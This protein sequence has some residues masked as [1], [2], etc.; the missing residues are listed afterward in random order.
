MKIIKKILFISFFICSTIIFNLD[1][2]YGG[3]AG[4]MW[5]WWTDPIDHICSCPK[6]YMIDCFCVTAGASID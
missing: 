3:G 4:Q 5:G 6:Y 2:T 1:V